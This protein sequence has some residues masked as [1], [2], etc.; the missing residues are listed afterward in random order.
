MWGMSAGTPLG[1]LN[2]QKYVLL[3]YL[4]K[5]TVKVFSNIVM[6]NGKHGTDVLSGDEG[7]DGT[8]FDGLF[9]LEA[10]RELME[11]F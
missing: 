6:G 4:N 1:L 9:V 7:R 10:H 3:Y 5:Q 11:G 2:T 8:V